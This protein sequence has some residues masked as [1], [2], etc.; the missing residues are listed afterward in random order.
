[1][2]WRLSGAAG[3]RAE[4]LTLTAGPRAAEAAWRDDVEGDLERREHVDAVAY[5]RLRRAEKTTAA[6]GPAAV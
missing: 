2:E 6:G 3:D 1:V 4:L 5:T